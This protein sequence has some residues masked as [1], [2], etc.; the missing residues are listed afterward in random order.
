MTGLKDLQ[1]DARKKRAEHFFK[2]EQEKLKTHILK[3]EKDRENR[4]SIKKENEM[5]LVKVIS[6]DK[7]I[8]YV[9]NTAIVIDPPN[10]TVEIKQNYVLNHY[11]IT[12]N[13]LWNGFLFQVFVSGRPSKKMVEK[14]LKKDEN[15]KILEQICKGWFEDEK[16]LGHLS[17][18]AFDLL[19]ELGYRLSE[20]MENDYSIIESLLDILK[21]SDVKMDDYDLLALAE[22]LRKMA[23][24][25]NFI[26]KIDLLDILIFLKD[27]R[28]RK[29]QK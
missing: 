24:D 4:R 18:E 29:G 28:E 25:Q 9:I 10:K 14:F 6:S 26:L 21:I 8:S 1:D 3:K 16:G 11:D 17:N 13:K 5:E 19:H 12:S 7:D 2:C 23:E 15:Q 22:R 27:K 20:I